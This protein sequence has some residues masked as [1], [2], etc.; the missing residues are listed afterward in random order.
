MDQINDMIDDK[1][2]DIRNTLS[3]ICEILKDKIEQDNAYREKSDNQIEGLMEYID[4]AK[5][6]L[7]VNAFP[8]FGQPRA[9]EFICPKCGGIDPNRK[10]GIKGLDGER[11]CLSL[12]CTCCG[13][14][15]E[16]PCLDSQI[17]N[18]KEK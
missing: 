16:E 8:P 9:F 12:C 10:Y 6:S 1:L 7:D 17:Q 18:Q 13:Y 5:K 4:N 2:G 3:E 11:D 14:H 15:W